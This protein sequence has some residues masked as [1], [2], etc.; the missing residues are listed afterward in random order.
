MKLDILTLLT[1]L[2]IASLIQFIILFIQYKVNKKYNG[3]VFW[4][5]GYAFMAAG[6]ML[7]FIRGFISVKL[8]AIISANSLILL[9]SIFLYLGVMRFIDKKESRG[10]IFTLFIVFILSFVYYTYFNDDI[11]LRTAIIYSAMA[12]ISLLTA[13]G[14]FFCKDYAIKASVYFN[15]FLFIIQGCF[16]TFRVFDVL[17]FESFSSLFTPT[18]MQTVSF[19]FLFIEGILVTFGLIVMVNQRLNAEMREDKENLELIF[20]TSPDAVLITRLHEGS[21]IDVNDSF[22]TY[23]GFSR[24]EVIGKTAFEINLWADP[25]ARRNLV[26]VLI[27]KGF[28]ENMEIVFHRK[29]GTKLRGLLSAR[30]IYLRGIPHIISVAR[31]MSERLDME[32]ALRESELKYRSLIENTSDVVFCVNEKGE[33]QFANNVF[34]STF[35]Q[36]PD[37]FIGKT[38]WDI[39]PEEH[40][41]YRQ[42][43]NRKVFETGETQTVEVT[44]PLPDKSLYFLAKANPI[45]DETGK[46]ILNLTTATDI[47]ERK[48]AEDALLAKSEEL[49]RYFTSSLDL[50]CIATTDGLFLR[51]NPEWER[52]LGYSIQDLEGKSFLDFVHPDDMEG[53]LS[54]MSR[55]NAQEK[56]LSFENRYRGKDG[57]YRWIEWRS[58]P[59]GNIIYA[60]ARDITERKRMD[61]SLRESESL[62]RLLAENSTDMISRHDE[63]GL[64]LYVSPACH[65]IL[66][67]E[68]EELIGHS[69]FE[70]I[71]PDDILEVER[72]RL[73]VNELSVLSTTVFRMR[74]KKGEYVWFETVS[75]RVKSELDGVSEIHAVSR[76]ITKRMLAELA[77]RESERKYRLITEFSSDVIWVLNLNQ[78]KYFFM[79]PVIYQLRG[80][81]VEEAMSEKMEDSLT[82][83]SLAEIKKA[84]TVYVDEFVKNPDKPLSYIAEVRQPCKDGSII[85]VE[86]SCKLRYNELHEIE[87]VGVSRNIE[88]RKKIEQA[89]R[90]SEEKLSTLFGAM[91]EMVALHELVFNE[92][93]DVVNYR[94]TDCNNAFTG[95]TGIKREDAVGKNA[96]EVYKVEPA[97]YLEEY[98][99]VALTGKAHEYTTYFEPMDK[100]FSISVVSPKKNHF[101]TITTDITGIRKVQEVISAKNKELEN[102]LYIASHDLRSPLVNIQG[103]S[104]RLQK[105]TDSIKSLISECSLAS[106]KKFDLDSI[107]NEGIPKTLNYIFSSVT[108]MDN[109]LKGLLYVSRTG[110]T[111][112]IVKEIDV[113]HLLEI[114]IRTYNY[115]LTELNAVVTA[116][117]LPPCH[118]DENLLNQLFSNIIGNAIKYRD[119][120]RQLVIE[121]TGRQEYTKVIYSVRDNGCGIEPRHLEKIW[122]VFYRVDSNQADA[123][124]G[125][126]LSIVERIAEKHNGKVW[127]ESEPGIGSVFHV[128]LQRNVFE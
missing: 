15:F 70:F 127:A 28:C 59:E 30:I 46:V 51:L 95:I 27:E 100:H 111:L 1:I 5:L 10:I 64:Y 39:Y 3:I 125:L 35:G 91:T 124:E 76:D 107:I 98:S 123:G 119:K 93:G 75:R 115:Q 66:G 18:L 11:K 34:A 21:F 72:S 80:L 97:P 61:D 13:Q 8:I 49:D 60:A 62:F 31:D 116:D 85:W 17:T 89:L 122:D 43:A 56:V 73:N 69:A 23:T 88:K 92:Q 48:R 77:L 79:S 37:Y 67:Y 103:F 20:N 54:A 41:D 87:V 42:E 7:L 32:A 128:E 22:V 102:Y 108:K 86:I 117:D 65:R 118:G 14:L 109:L 78:N 110:R 38:F 26:T 55:L 74:S 104:R 81:T 126:G 50:L 94:I 114:I 83:E 25:N 33:Y 71:H 58:H 19:L 112:M 121:I 120:D 45:K 90:E 36:T 12:V 105:Q 9:G 101:A 2:C 4:V 96:T 82:E 16:F 29:D 99:R 40:A 53:T 24:E 57:N 63:K 52:V 106:E 113:N 68:P 6:Y 44:V 84:I 47:T